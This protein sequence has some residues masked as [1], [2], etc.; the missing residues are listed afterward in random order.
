MDVMPESKPAR[1]AKPAAPLAPARNSDGFSIQAV[2]LVRTTTIAN[3][4]L[5]QMADQ[6]ASILMGATF[7]VFT[8]S[9]GQASS[10]ALSLPLLVMAS[11]AFVSAFCAVLA[12][13][14]SIR[15]P[16][17]PLERQNL[18]FFGHFA[19]LTEEEFV[20]S[21]LERLRSDDTMFTTML[22]DI[23]QNGQVLQK[24]KYRYLTLA[25]Y[26]FLAGLTLTLISFLAQ[27]GGEIG[28]LFT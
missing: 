7:L 26:V 20:D 22:R 24:K 21:M 25:Y 19:N 6:K 4:T 18:L 17:S 27:Y 5:S 13:V 23:H 14:P 3:L 8:L 12:I 15:P 1:P 2:H 28:R 16:K 10:G 9:V 11:F